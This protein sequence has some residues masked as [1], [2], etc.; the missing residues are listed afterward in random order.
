MVDATEVAYVRVVV[1]ITN[2]VNK[3]L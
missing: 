3:Q 1:R 2:V